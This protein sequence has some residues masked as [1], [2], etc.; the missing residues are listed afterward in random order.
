MRRKHH[1]KRIHRP[2]CCSAMIDA[3][4]SRRL[5]AAVI[6]GTN[7]DD[8]FVISVGAGNTISL[9]FNGGLQSI[10]APADGNVEVHGLDGNDDLTLLN[11]GALQFFLHGEQGDD[12]FVIG[13]G[14]LLANVLT[15]VRIIEPSGAGNDTCTIN[16]LNGGGLSWIADG[17]SFSF[18]SISSP[19]ILLPA[20]VDPGDSTV[21]RASNNADTLSLRTGVTTSGAF[22]PKTTFD[23]GGGN[24]TVHV[25]GSQQ[26]VDPNL[27]QSST[28]DAGA[29][30]GDTITFDDSNAASA[31]ADLRFDETGLVG[32]LKFANFVNL[33]VKTHQL[34]GG[35][36]QPVTFRGFVSP[37]PVIS[38]TGVAGDDH[39]QFGEPG[40]PITGQNYWGSV[41]LDLNT[42]LDSVDINY[43]TGPS[44]NWIFHDSGLGVGLGPANFFAAGVIDLVINGTNGPDVF[45]VQDTPNLWNITL[46]ARDGADQLRTGTQLDLDDAFDNSFFK[47]IGGA[48]VDSVFLDDSAD[49][50]GDQDQYRIADGFI[51]KQ[52]FGSGLSDFTV[53]IEQAEALALHMDG[54]SNRLDYDL[55]QY[56][57]VEIFGNSGNDQFF[58]RES[59]GANTDVLAATLCPGVI[60]HGGAGLDELILNDNSGTGASAQ[61][62]FD[63]A[64]YTY[65][66]TA[67]GPAQVITFD[68][69]TVLSLTA[70]NTRDDAITVDVKPLVADFSIAAGGGDDTIT[71]GGGDLDS[72]NLLLNDIT[73]AG[74]AGNDAIVFDDRL[75]D[76]NDGTSTYTLTSNA[77][78]KGTL[79]LVYGSC[80]Q[81]TLLVSDRL[82]AGQLN[83]VP[84]VNIN[85]VSGFL[86]S[87]T[88]IGGANRQAAVNIAN[89]NLTNIAGVINVN[90]SGGL[91]D[92]MT[93]NDQATTIA[94]ASVFD[95][96]ATQI[97]KVNTNQTINYSGVTQLT[98]NARDAT[99]VGD[100]ITV[101]AI[102]AGTA[103]IVNALAGNDTLTLGPSDISAQILGVVSLNGGAGSNGLVIDNTADATLATQTLTTSTFTD[104]LTHGF[105]GMTRLNVNHGTGGTDLSITAIALPATIAGGAGDDAI[106]IGNGSLATGLATNSP[107]VGGGGNDSLS[108]LGQ[109]DS[110]TR[111]YAFPA[112]NQFRF[113]DTTTGK[114]VTF[115]EMEQATLHCGGGNDTIDVST[116]SIPLSIHAGAGSDNVNITA[117]TAPVTVDTGPENPPVLFGRQGD[118]INAG[119]VS[120]FPAQVVVA[121]SDTVVGLNITGGSTLRIA[122]AAVLVRAKPSVDGGF[123]VGTLDIANGA[124]L[125]RAGSIAPD[126]RSLLTTG[127]AG[128]AWN[129]TGAGGAINSSFAAASGFS[130]GVGHGLGS[131]IGIS[132]I[133]GFTIEP[134]DTLLGYTLDGD[135]DLNGNVDIADFSRIAANFN[136]GGKVWTSGDSTYDNTTDIADFAG[137]AANFNQVASSIT[138]RYRPFSQRILEAL[139]HPGAP[140]HTAAARGNPASIGPLRIPARIVDGLDPHF[141][142]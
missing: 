2:A 94:A 34:P 85:G 80:E 109:N 128:G 72:N 110:G 40:N 71:L 133:G 27:P 81:Q 56:D 142:H 19:F 9:T 16:D 57:D 124:L 126:F 29:G 53:Q 90:L 45:T 132:S 91:N 17:D 22:P 5:L 60:F 28:I 20:M 78:A 92:R 39:V 104:G 131:E 101:R 54:D 114:V 69:F 118:S 115:S 3:L 24:D 49:V 107:V 46:N 117:S 38:I 18:L 98:L 51:T 86:N 42:G 59:I 65:R 13:N 134:G 15:D 63:T 74:G 43:T 6:N 62:L 137:L 89:G 61:H 122:N 108:L 35:A 64:N 127:R 8:T 138:A 76:I 47:F 10:P 33:Q 116:A 37:A 4:E 120:T 88:I 139:E 96:T 68:S 106:S 135:A 125:V 23:L 112:L 14:N 7:G 111:T 1:R 73:I 103:L 32:Q 75:D 66:A 36:A 79:G 95:V 41:T 140:S 93:I 12:D 102:P 11:T 84:V 44:S 119:F 58:N 67:G 129:G 99:S 83:T 25:G 48:H 31:R 97:R 50:L 113:G 55:N 82:L 52:N 130:D 105:T 21:V 30:G 87:T 26:R 77:L 70:S 136:A 141:L 123:A 100:T 121:A